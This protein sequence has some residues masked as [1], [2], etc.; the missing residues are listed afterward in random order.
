MDKAAAKEKKRKKA[1]AEEVI[2]LRDEPAAASKPKPEA[3]QLWA[4]KY[5]PRS[6]DDLAI[7]RKRIQ[8]VKVGWPGFS[9][10]SRLRSHSLTCVS[11]L[12]SG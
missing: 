4:D 3:D 9:I 1:E 12:R 8:E 10:S 2:V 5:P 6:S 7:Y 11:S